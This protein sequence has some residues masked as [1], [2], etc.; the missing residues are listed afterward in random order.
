[1]IATDKAVA[2]SLIALSATIEEANEAVE[3]YLGN[4]P[5]PS[6]KLACLKDLFGSDHIKIL[7]HHDDPDDLVYTLW[8]N[9]I[10]NEKYS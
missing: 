8:L 4:S 9:A 10:I 5:S 3:D 2:K 1:M 7:G 6:E